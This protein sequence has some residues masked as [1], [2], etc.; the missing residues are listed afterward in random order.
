MGGVCVLVS[1]NSEGVALGRFCSIGSLSMEFDFGRVRAT[2]WDVVLR[3]PVGADGDF[4]RVRAA[5]VR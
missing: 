4:G 1:Q 3:S 5:E 2:R